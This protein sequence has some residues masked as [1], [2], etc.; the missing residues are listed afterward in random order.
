MKLNPHRHLRVPVPFVYAMLA[1]LAAL[2]GNAFAAPAKL[3]LITDLG[4]IGSDARCVAN[5]INASGIVAGYLRPSPTA[6]ETCSEVAVWRGS[7]A[8]ATDAPGQATAINA[9]GDVVGFTYGNSPQH[10]F[11][12]HDG[13]MK[14]LGGLGG[15]TSMAL[16]VKDSGVVV[17]RA[18]VGS[19]VFHAFTWTAGGGMK[20]LNPR[21]GNP[22]SSEAAAINRAGQIVGIL[23]CEQ[24]YL[25]DPVRGMKLLGALPGHGAAAASSLNNRGQ[26]VGISMPDCNDSIEA[27]AF[28]W[29]PVKGMV[30]VGT[31]GAYP[32][33]ANG[34]NDEGVVVGESRKKRCASSRAFIWQD[35]VMTD[36][37]S[38][39]S[40][41]S[42]WTLYAAAAI[43]SRGQI[44]GYGRG[45][46]GEH[47]FLLTPQS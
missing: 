23:G 22:P 17:G 10:A 38:L 29:D 7:A 12:Y 25:F 5:A 15:E 14:N 9:N 31:L 47:A 44:T 41:S 3:Y 42:G 43:N 30:D 27:H 28:F 46:A 2:P 34:I 26:V 20:D 19:A 11:I 21:L 8:T 32:T 39:V 35:G 16:G 24:A 33:F 40:H 45:P 4:P 13:V 18:D 1:V 6:A 37:N 36:L